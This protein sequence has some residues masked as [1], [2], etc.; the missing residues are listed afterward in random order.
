MFILYGPLV[1]FLVGTAFG[2]RAS[3]LGQVRIRW[4][5]AIAA[6]M[7]VQLLLF[8]PLAALI[9]PGHPLGVVAFLA[10]SGIG[11]LA[12]LAN[13]RQPGLVLLFGGALLNLAV[14]FA[15]G[16][17]MPASAEA[18]A[19]LGWSGEQGGFSNSAHLAAPAL[20]WLTDIFA[21]P[22]WLPFANVF[23]L[24]DILIAMGCGLFVA[25]SMLRTEP[26]TPGRG[27][28]PLSG[29]SRAQHQLEA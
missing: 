22:P 5:P 11:L 20:P 8:G 6:A 17:V 28:T 24:G 12:A 21:L 27:S 10:S 9:E 14:I 13:I 25:A 1:G 19:V 4:F 2:G 3:R 15:N 18:L 16:G 7:A 29:E 26:T 23:S